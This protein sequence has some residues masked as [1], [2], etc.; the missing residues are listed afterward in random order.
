MERKFTETAGVQVD[1]FGAWLLQ[2]VRQTFP[3]CRF[4]ARSFLK[5][6]KVRSSLHFHFMF[7]SIFTEVA[8]HSGSDSSP[9]SAPKST[10][11]APAL[12]GL[13]SSDVGPRRGK[14]WETAHHLWSG[15]GRQRPATA[16][17][18]DMSIDIEKVVISKMMLICGDMC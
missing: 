3:C 13:V 11:A 15:N 12:D 9:G 7:I 4:E 2:G 1:L 10:S 16:T 18:I 6:V 14:R 5:L 17:D 8:L